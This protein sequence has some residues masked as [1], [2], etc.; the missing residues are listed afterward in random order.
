M[1]LSIKI[2]RIQPFPPGANPVGLGQVAIPILRRFQPGPGMRS[3]HTYP[4]GQTVGLGCL[5]P[6]AHD[7]FAGTDSHGIPR[8]IAAFIQVEVV[9]MIGQCK[10]ILR[11]SFFIQFDQGIRFPFFGFPR[12]DDV[13]EAKLIRTT[14]LTN[15]ILVLTRA[16]VIHEAGIPI[17]EARFTLRTPMSPNAKLGIL[18][19]LRSLV[20]LFQ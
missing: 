6:T 8:L 2:L 15:M 13:F 9:V 19:P 11:T 20:V 7:I 14:V 3:V 16:L 1:A 4:K 5:C 17:S 18:E 12:I 10:E